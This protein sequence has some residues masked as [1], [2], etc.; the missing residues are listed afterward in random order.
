MQSNVIWKWVN[1]SGVLKLFSD[2][3][4]WWQEIVVLFHIRSPLILQSWFWLSNV[5]GQM[6]ANLVYILTK[7]DLKCREKCMSK[8]NLV[9]LIQFTFMLVLAFFCR[10]DIVLKPFRIIK[11]E[12]NVCFMSG[13]CKNE[14]FPLLRALNSALIRR[15][16]GYGAEDEGGECVAADYSTRRPVVTRKPWSPS[17][18]PSSAISNDL[19]DDVALPPSPPSQPSSS[20]AV[21]LSLFF[22]A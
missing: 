19:Q 13:N 11:S 20:G 10:K 6:S 9:W 3:H 14:K 12:F 21:N 8:F 5:R 16:E 15:T 2:G 7:D 17:V 1:G 22:C 4:S 18:T